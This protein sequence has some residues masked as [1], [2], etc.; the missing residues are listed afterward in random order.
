[1]S[2]RNGPRARCGGEP[3]T[4]LMIP[5]VA[6]TAPGARKRPKELPFRS[7][8]C[9]CKH[10]HRCSR[11]GGPFGQDLQY[12]GGPCLGR[13]LSTRIETGRGRRA[14]CPHPVHHPRP[15]GWWAIR[16][17]A[18]LPGE[19]KRPKEPRSLVAPT[20]VNTGQITRRS[21]PLQARPTIRDA[22][23]RRQGTYP[24]DSS[25]MSFVDDGCPPCIHHHRSSG[26]RSASGSTANPS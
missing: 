21:L 5:A 24:R 9:R 1:M 17:G 15:R 7:H 26:H 19:R 2:G 22:T 3:D 12:G 13:G 25:Q 16:A 4:A 14:I 6:E 10:L 18:K 23:L 11:S 20:N 8:R